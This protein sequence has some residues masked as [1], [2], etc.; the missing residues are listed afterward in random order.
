MRRNAKSWMQ[1]VGLYCLRSLFEQFCGDPA[2]RQH[3]EH[4]DGDMIF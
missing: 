2:K 1:P 3:S 4:G